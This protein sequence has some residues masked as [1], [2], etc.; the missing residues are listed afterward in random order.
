MGKCGPVVFHVFHPFYLVSALTQSYLCRD[1]FVI[2]IYSFKRGV[3]LTVQ[4]V[5][6]PLLV[7][8]DII[9]LLYRGNEEIHS[10]IKSSLF[11]NCSGTVQQIS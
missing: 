7:Y 11:I 3:R 4:S 1:N 10:E 5:I 2:K 6:H 9:C 8:K